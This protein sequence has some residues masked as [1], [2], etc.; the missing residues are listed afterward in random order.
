MSSSTPV[1][2]MSSTTAMACRQCEQTENSKACTTI[3]VCGKTPETAALQDLLVHALK[4]LAAWSVAAKSAGASMA[5]LAAI[6]AFVPNAL[7]TTLTNV[8]FDSA[9]IAALLHETAAKR[10]AAVALV[11]KYKGKAP[12]SPAANFQVPAGASVSA[13]E[14]LANGDKFVGIEGAQ[15]RIG[16]DR[17][18]LLELITYGVKGLCAYAEHVQ[19]LKALDAA[20][21]ADI[22]ALLAFTAVEDQ[23]VDAMLTAALKVGEVNFKVTQLLEDAHKATFGPMVPTTVQTHAKAG[24]AILVSGHDMTDLQRV[25]EAT[26]GRGISVYTHGE[27]LPG[28]S[29]AKLKQHKHLVGHYG[30]AWQ[31]QK[32]EFAAFPG[33]IL[34][35]SNCI[36]QPAKSY[37]DRI[38]TTG[39]VGWPGVTHIPAGGNLAPLL[40]AATSAKGFATD[41]A[42]R[43]SL[44]IGYGKD[45]LLG[46][47]DAI[48]DAVKAGTVKRFFF[49]GG[50]DGTEGERNYFTQLAQ[51]LPQ[52]TV[53]LTAGC[54]KFRFN[55]LLEGQKVGPFPRVLDTGQC[56]DISGAIAVAGGLAGKLGCGV[57]DLPLDFAVSWLEQKAVSQLLTCLHLGLKGIHLGPNLPAFVTPTVLNVLVDKFK[58]APTTT[59]AKDFPQASY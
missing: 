15:Q 30:S 21:N 54:A 45:T 56:N 3:G 55:R 8:N 6:D 43:P 39:P 47:A 9:R 22:V 7:F 5:E 24:K 25:L 58:L 19:M 59:P 11:K 32:L 27:M 53:I 41:E 48:V 12:D 18:G 13:L 42:A 28:N 49:I 46:A 51:A 38:F 16:A 10:A 33:A 2:M 40:A 31:N 57:G 50:C 29:Y 34:M 36:I 4:G 17:A 52:S 20:T 35:T 37:R 26:A 23:S 44:T 1:R 14:A